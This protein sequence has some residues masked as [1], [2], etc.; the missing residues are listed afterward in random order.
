M[1]AHAKE[2]REEEDHDRPE[3][4]SASVGSARVRQ[5]V[6]RD[7]GLKLTGDE[8]DTIA[9]HAPHNYYLR[10]LERS[11]QL[12]SL[13]TFPQSRGGVVP[14]VA[15]CPYVLPTLSLHAP[16]TPKGSSAGDFYEALEARDQEIRRGGWGSLLDRIL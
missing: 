2:Q 10:S 11:E 14:V 7:L 13:P 1:E 9:R 16:P 12:V 3:D 15:A 6:L 5:S 4:E 8:M